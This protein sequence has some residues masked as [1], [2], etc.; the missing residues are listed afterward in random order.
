MVVFLFGIEMFYDSHSLTIDDL[1]YYDIGTRHGGYLNV[2]S[3]YASS[4]SVAYAKINQYSNAWYPSTEEG[5]WLAIDLGT[6]F[7]LYGYGIEVCEI[8]RLDLIIY[9]FQDAECL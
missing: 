9:S 8:F 7:R 3:Y 6:V 5:S 4:G 1:A 2:N